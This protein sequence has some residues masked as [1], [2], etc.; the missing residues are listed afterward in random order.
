MRDF[1]IKLAEDEN[2]SKLSSGIGHGQYWERRSATPSSFKFTRLKLSVVAIRGEMSANEGAKH[3]SPNTSSHPSINLEVT[4]G[5]AYRGQSRITMG[6]RIS[7]LAR[8][9]AMET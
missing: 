6:S 2:T 1:L 7:V 3:L 5:S 4:F 8:I 9:Y